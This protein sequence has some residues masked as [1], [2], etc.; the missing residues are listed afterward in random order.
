MC[1][2]EVSHKLI[3]G[4][5]WRDQMRKTLCLLQ[6][7]CR[8]L[9]IVLCKPHSQKS[10]E[11]FLGHITSL[12]RAAERP[13]GTYS[14]SLYKLRKERTKLESGRTLQINKFP[15]SYGL[16]AFKMSYCWQVLL[17]SC[18]LKVAGSFIESI[19]FMLALPLFLL[20]SM[21]PGFVVFS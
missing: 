5:W 12:R 6:T 2:Q 11:C 21:F 1:V 18:K 14:L 9:T 10:A 17:R 4:C 19:P 7:V 15:H 3:R 16:M 13:H 20:P 8:I